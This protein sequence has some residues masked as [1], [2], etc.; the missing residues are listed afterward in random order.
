ML[1]HGLPRDQGTQHPCSVFPVAKGQLGTM[2]AKFS[3]GVQKVLDLQSSARKDQASEDAW[4]ALH[5]GI[6][7]CRN[8][9]EALEGFSQDARLCVLKFLQEWPK[10]R[11][12][13]QN[14]GKECHKILMKSPSWAETADSDTF[15]DFLQS[16]CPDASMELLQ[17]A[18][19]R[20]KMDAFP[21]GRPGVARLP[22]DVAAKNQRQIRGSIASMEKFGYAFPSD[23]QSS[24]LDEATEAFEKLHKAMTFISKL[25]GKQY[26][27]EGLEALL[28]PFDPQW[29]DVVKF[30]S[31]MEKC[32]VR[33]SLSL[34]VHFVVSTLRASSSGFR[35]ALEHSDHSWSEATKGPEVAEF[36]P[37]PQVAEVLDQEQI[38][39]Q[40]LETL[41]PLDTEDFDLAFD[42]Q[43]KEFKRLSDKSKSSKSRRPAAVFRR[44]FA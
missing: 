25:Q 44:I 18:T 42:L 34:R 2:A 31:S 9:P 36:S 11:K 41:E 32:G 17:P 26:P 16:E 30:L 39:C 27:P 20:L 23:F 35:Q 13:L 37:Y 29:E 12:T 33:H 28:C 1:V 43:S 21:S 24:K 19:D 6:R 22:D 5:P 38:S 7:G 10:K 15:R 8:R 14:Q 4:A 3:E 40:G